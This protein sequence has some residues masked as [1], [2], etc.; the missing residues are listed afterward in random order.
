M[1]PRRIDYLPTEVDFFTKAIVSLIAEAGFFGTDDESFTT[2]FDSR[3]TE[4]DSFN[5]EVT[6]SHK[7]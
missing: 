2:E 4:V 3:I 7:K 1:V 6:F 5:E